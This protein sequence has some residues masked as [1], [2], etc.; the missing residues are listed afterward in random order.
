MND[1]LTTGKSQYVTFK[2]DDEIFAFDVARVREVLDIRTITKIPGALG[3]MRGVINV[4]GSVV[5]VADLRSKFGLSETEF[6]ADTRIVVMELSMDD[7]IMVFGVL[8]DSVHDVR[9]FEPDQIE[10]S[11]RIG[12]RWRTEFIRG[13]GKQDDQFFIIL[14]TDRV[15]S[16]EELAIA[17]AS[18]QAE[19]TC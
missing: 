4:R 6:T 16:S 14:D 10:A 9:E 5:P 1:T 11:P 3:F 18:Q 17:E 8:A 15:F 7:E 13:I 19:L 2:L 12:T